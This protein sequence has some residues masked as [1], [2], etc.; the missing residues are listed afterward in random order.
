ME[1]AIKMLAFS[2]LIYLDQTPFEAERDVRI[3]KG[4]PMLSAFY[5]QRGDSFQVGLW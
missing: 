1:T 4:G 2:R 5:A 3:E